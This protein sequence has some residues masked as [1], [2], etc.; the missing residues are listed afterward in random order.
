MSTF[1]IPVPPVNEANSVLESTDNPEKLCDAGINFLRNNR[2][3]EARQVFR[4]ALQLVPNNNLYRSY[5]GI[6]IALV[7]RQTDQALAICREA[8]LGELCRA[9]VFYNLG[10]VHLMRREKRL[11][12]RAFRDGLRLDR[13]HPEILQ[14][15]G[16][17]GVRKG[18]VFSFLDRGHP[19]NIRAGRILSRVKLR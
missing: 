19:I 3:W 17:M 10:R 18:P 14:A 13:E 6:T 12:R 16:R 8:T 2:P 7:D 11:A 15:L 1:N 9:D 5:Y 4:R